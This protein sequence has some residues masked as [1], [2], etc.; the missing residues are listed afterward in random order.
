M[1]RLVGFFLLVFAALFVLREVPYV[2][3][4][5][6]IPLL[7]FYLAAILV[8]VVGARLAT[9]AA[10]RAKQKRLERELGGVDTPYNRGKLGL[11]MLQQGRAQQAVPHL[12]A[13]LEADPES[14][15]FQF[16]LGLALLESG[17]AAEAVARLERVVERNEDY[18]YG[19][20]L[21]AL[22]EARCRAGSARAA[23]DAVEQ[24]DRSFGPT[25]ES[26]YRRGKALRA[27]GDRSGS[28]RAFASIGEVASKLPAY[29]RRAAT[30]WWLK[31]QLAKLGF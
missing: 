18:A 1:L 25:A 19:A 22:S 30:G 10:D 11:L 27:I 21:L 23:L 13:A 16:R 3:A 2:G 9:A 14:E 31:A 24:H 15:E 7:G 26:C 28:A 8:S 12:A 29:H 4:P 5:F 17:A 6:R 20:A